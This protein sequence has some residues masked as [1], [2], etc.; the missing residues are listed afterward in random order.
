M[1]H[2]YAVRTLRRHGWRTALDRAGIGT[3]IHYP[4]PIHLQVA[5]RGRVGL[6]SGGLSESE[7]AA[8]KVL[9]PPM[10]PE[11]GAADVARVIATVKSR[12]SRSEFLNDNGLFLRVAFVY[13]RF[14][15]QLSAE[16]GRAQK[17]PKGALV[18]Q[19][20]YLRHHAECD[21]R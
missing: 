16:D 2:Q 13:E 6:D 19:I 8:C 3:V 9:S 1:F 17:E 15:G 4:V 10:F 18:H 7:R 14:Q 5:Y 11:L 20:V 12:C 21:E